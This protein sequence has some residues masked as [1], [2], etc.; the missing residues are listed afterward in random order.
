[1]FGSFDRCG[2]LRE[3]GL[4]I[5]R[6]SSILV[7]LALWQTLAAQ[8]YRVAPPGGP[9]D[10]L[11]AILQTA[12]PGSD[13]WDSEARFAEWD[14]ALS[15]FAGRLKSNA[16]ILQFIHPDFEGTPLLPDE[17]LVAKQGAV[18][19]QRGTPPA[20][21]RAGGDFFLHEIGRWRKELAAI[22][23][24][25]FKIVSV[26]PAASDIVFF[27][28]G[29]SSEDLPV[30]FR[31]EW[32]IE[33]MRG[34]DGAWKILRLWAGPLSV[35]RAPRKAFRDVTAEA[36]G[37]NGS[38]W[39]QLVP[40][41]D[42]WR[43]RLDAALGVALTGHHGVS[44]ADVNGDGWE[45]IYVPQPAGL[46]NLLYLNRG[47]LRFEDGTADSGLDVLDPTY[48]A[49]FADFDNDGDQDVFLVSSKLMLFENDG[50][51]RFSLVKDAGLDRFG[52]RDGS[53]MAASAADYD[54][55]GLLDVYVA[56]HTQSAWVESPGT[57]LPEP[58][59]DANNGAPNLLLRNV[60]GRFAEVSDPGIHENNR[61]FS[62][63]AAWGDYD[64]DGDPDLYVAN[65]F[66]RNNLYR[67][68]GDGSFHDVAAQA[69]VEDLGAG[70]SV[71]WEDFDNDGRLDL[72]VGNMWS[73]AGLRVTGQDRFHSARNDTETAA[74]RRHAR[75]NSL[76]RNRG[77]GT[78]EDVT[79]PAGVGLGRWAWSSEF[80]DFDNDGL[81]DIYVVN[82]FIT[83]EDTGDL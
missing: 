80:F 25:K 56:A 37:A 72:Y 50:P 5:R 23:G 32:R 10:K 68:N 41:V 49:L 62:F 67:N 77:D 28:S 58:Y 46:P 48:H 40:G 54:R 2:E 34:Q 78:F 12:Q 31:G 20:R 83:G 7:M 60:G 33:W 71:A 57:D 35:A 4:M 81:E 73:S 19:V 8:N 16:D 47:G 39:K 53:W 61:R 38:Y 52:E 21:L 36:L 45:D 30:Q 29:S 9:P 14:R 1:M 44:V 15:E 3:N 13:E 82:G 64:G 17:Y 59:H 6:L 55:D 26:E 66:G 79:Q 65:D 22:D 27:V 75:G 51:G 70:M 76:F 42:R 69:G 63:A 74:L 11:Q 18:R 43:K 24:A